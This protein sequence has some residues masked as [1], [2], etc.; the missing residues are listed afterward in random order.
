M[1]SFCSDTFHE[2][3]NRQLHESRMHSERNIQCDKCEKK[4]PDLHILNLHIQN[5]H[6]MKK[7]RICPICEKA[8]STDTVYKCHMNRHNGLRPYTCETCGNGYHTNRDLKNH[9]SVHTLP[10]KCHLCEKSFSAKGVLDDHIRKHGGEKL[11]CRHL[12]GSSYLDI[13][14][15]NRHEKNCVNNPE[16]G[17]SWSLCSK[18]QEK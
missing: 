17:S 2:N 4:F 11:D 7:P 1:C 14:N 10:Y 12:C 6:V 3:K 13:R 15:R 18:L 5:V 9:K 8:C 16:K